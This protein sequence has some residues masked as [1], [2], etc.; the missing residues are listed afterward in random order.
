MAFM[1]VFG[2]CILA[3]A[4]LGG[5]PPAVSA[6]LPGDAGEPSPR[7]VPRNETGHPR[8]GPAQAAARARQRYGGRVL[9]VTLERRGT[10]PHYRVKLLEDGNVR[11]VRVPAD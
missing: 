3:A 4:L 6:P 5:M 2:G 11:S 7:A 10:R 9:D 8:I 1:K